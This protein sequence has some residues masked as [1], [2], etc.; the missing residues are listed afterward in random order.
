MVDTAFQEGG[1]NSGELNLKQFLNAVHK[2]INMWK[3]F[4]FLHT[5]LKLISCFSSP[6]P[7]FL[8]VD[9][10]FLSYAATLFSNAQLTYVAFVLV[11]YMEKHSTKSIKLRAF[12]SIARSL[13]NPLRL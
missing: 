10:S 13:R 7:S 5:R 11:R 4:V 6:A 9:V 1:H 12:S 8:I 3:W 2:L